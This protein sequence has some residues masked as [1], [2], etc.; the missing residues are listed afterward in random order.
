MQKST[1]IST[2][3]LVLIVGLTAITYVWIS[4]THSEVKIANEHLQNIHESLERQKSELTAERDCLK[5]PS[6]TPWPQPNPDD[7][8]CGDPSKLATPTP[9]HGH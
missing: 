9:Q 1:L 3:A 8:I 2:I 4:R 7:P 5:M 6:R